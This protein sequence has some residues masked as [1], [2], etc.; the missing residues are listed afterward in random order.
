MSPLNC[1]R[2]NLLPDYN[3]H[4]V[5]S[6][7]LGT[8]FYCRAFAA[9]IGDYAHDRGDLTA[10]FEYRFRHT[11]DRVVDLA[12]VA[13]VQRTLTC[14]SFRHVYERRL[15]PRLPMKPEAKGTQRPRMMYVA[16]TSD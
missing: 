5:A 8:V 15:K 12:V 3:R 13:D 16:F 1:P 2:R 4:A 14:R 9:S 6:L 10:G 11:V 7:V